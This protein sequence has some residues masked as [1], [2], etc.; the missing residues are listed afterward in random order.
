MVLYG[1]TPVPAPEWVNNT[2]CLD[3][4]CVFGG[5]LT[6]L[7]YPERELVSVVAKRAYYQAA[8]AFLPGGADAP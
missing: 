8:E 4:G 2:L 6:A 1:H 5:R 7:R 3:T